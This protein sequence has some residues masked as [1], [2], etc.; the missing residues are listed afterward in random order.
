MGPYRV[1]MKNENY[2]G[3]AMSRSIGDGIAHNIGVSDLPEIIEF[4][5]FYNITKYL[6]N[7]LIKC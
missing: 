5:I 2:P 7:I 6:D 4:E 1:W 3:L